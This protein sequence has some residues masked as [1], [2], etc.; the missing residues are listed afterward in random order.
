MA[1]KN[2]IPL[3]GAGLCHNKIDFEPGFF[4]GSA[5][6][7]AITNPTQPLGC[8]NFVSFKDRWDPETRIP[9]PPTIGPCISLSERIAI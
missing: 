8:N 9:S 3:I 6:G 4:G 5:T 1:G 7:N 2:F